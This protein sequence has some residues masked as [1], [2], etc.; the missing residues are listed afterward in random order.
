MFCNQHLIATDVIYSMHEEFWFKPVHVL[1]MKI[2]FFGKWVKKQ[3]NNTHLINFFIFLWKYLKTF[4]LLP[5]K[6]GYFLWE[7]QME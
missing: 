1:W 5:C 7:M 3:N 2:Y 6:H 4:I